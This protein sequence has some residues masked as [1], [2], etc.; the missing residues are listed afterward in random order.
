MDKQ[1]YIERAADDPARIAPRLHD[2][3]HQPGDRQH[4]PEEVRVA[5]RRVFRVPV[6]R[7]LVL[8]AEMRPIQSPQAT[9]ETPKALGL[10]RQT[11]DADSAP[12]SLWQFCTRDLRTERCHAYE[13]STGREPEP[14]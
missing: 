11:R 8:A 6:H 4:H 13:T 1:C 10:P 7:R 3:R 2:Q 9:Y 5:A 14:P 12:D